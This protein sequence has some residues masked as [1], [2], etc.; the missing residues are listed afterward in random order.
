VSIVVKGRKVPVTKIDL[1][2][3]WA[4]NWPK[5]IIM[6]FCPFCSKEVKAEQRGHLIWCKECGDRID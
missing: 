1:K 6:T 5:K 2:S 4:K 3:T